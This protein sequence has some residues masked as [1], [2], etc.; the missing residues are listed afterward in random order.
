M[1]E[2]RQIKSQE[3]IGFIRVA[4][5][6]GKD[7]IPT[8]IISTPNKEKDNLIVIKTKEQIDKLISILQEFQKT[9]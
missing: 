1:G 9:F 3:Q 8:V 4:A 7:E 5:Y 6:I 2:V